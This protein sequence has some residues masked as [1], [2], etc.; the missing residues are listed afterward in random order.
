MIAHTQSDNTRGGVEGCVIQCKPL[1][2][3]LLL[4]L[5]RALCGPVADCTYTKA[6]HEEVWRAV[7]FSVS[8]F[9]SHY[10]RLCVPCSV[11]HSRYMIAHTQ[12]D[13]TR[14]GV[15]GCVIQCKPLQQPLL[16]ALCRA[17]CGVGT[18]QCVIH[19]RYMIAHTQSDNTRG[20]VEGCVIQCKPLQQPLLPALC[21]ALCGVGTM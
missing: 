16:P 8:R 6:M 18:M 2:Q 4:A 13:N 5:C 7:S 17:L 10:Y 20:G 3:P 19:S 14:G 9:N 1:Q 11:T 21:R 15:E 12:S